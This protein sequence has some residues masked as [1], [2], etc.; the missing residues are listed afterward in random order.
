MDFDASSGLGLS[1]TDGIARRTIACFERYEDA[2]A[3]VDALSDRGFPVERL[4]IVGRD[5]QLVERV[6]GRLTAAGTALRGAGSGAAFAALFGLVFGLWLSPDGLSLLATI[7]YWLVVG[8]A[9]GALVGLLGYSAT[10]GQ[11]DFTSVSGV[12]A[13]HFEVVAEEAVAEEAQRLAEA[14]RPGTTS[15]SGGHPTPP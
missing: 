13:G 12:Q 10:G 14:A 8:A 3:L 9:L 15:S 7:L 5:L 2:Q 11:R 1:H 6:T 4:R